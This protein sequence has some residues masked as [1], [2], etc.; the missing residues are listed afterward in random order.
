VFW[1]ANELQFVLFGGVD[2]ERSARVLHLDEQA[3]YRPIRGALVA[4][5][6]VGVGAAAGLDAREIHTDS[7]L[8]R[9]LAPAVPAVG[10]A[11]ETT[12]ATAEILARMQE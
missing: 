3:Q 1:G 8:T 2:D 9:H 4:G 10:S 6:G 7:G 11:P 12:L 5:V